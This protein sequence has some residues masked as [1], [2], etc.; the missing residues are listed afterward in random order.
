MFHQKKVGEEMNEIIVEDD[1]QRAI[2]RI[3]R[4]WAK[5]RP[6]KDLKELQARIDEFLEYVD[7]FDQVPEKLDLALCIG[8]DRHTLARWFNGSGCSP[9]WCELIRR[10]FAVIES[11]V[12]QQ[13]N[14]GRITPIRSIWLEKSRFGM[15]DQ[16][17]KSEDERDSLDTR[18]TEAYRLPSELLQKYLALKDTGETESSTDAYRLPE[19]LTNSK[20]SLPEDALE[21]SLYNEYNVPFYVNDDVNE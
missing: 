21:D 8:R 16:A 11:T 4:R 15:S 13:G 2:N 19:P 10:A 14:D 6:P 1:R 12:R 3:K 17:G 9:E 7:M 20:W 5:R 18:Q